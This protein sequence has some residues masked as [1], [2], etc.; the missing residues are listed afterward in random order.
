MHSIGQDHSNIPQELTQPPSFQSL[1]ESRTSDH[2]SRDTAKCLPFTN[3]S[4]PSPPAM[5]EKGKG[6]GKGK[7]VSVQHANMSPEV[8]GRHSNMIPEISGHHA[9]MSPEVVVI[10][11]EDDDD[12]DHDN[13]DDDDDDDATNNWQRWDRR[14]RESILARRKNLAI[15][16]GVKNEPLSPSESPPRP[17]T[18]TEEC[19]SPPQRND[20]SNTTNLSNSD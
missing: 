20:F 2:L 13:D 14:F 6:K 10:D 3:P 9:N 17:D 5:T 19:F 16:K 12:D 8:S 18:E 11:S 7:Q 15:A 4:P 1:I